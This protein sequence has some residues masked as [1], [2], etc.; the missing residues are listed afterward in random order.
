M[1]A[2]QRI[3][4][5]LWLFILIS[6]AGCLPNATVYYRPSVDVE[7][8]YEQGHCVPV[9]KYVFFNIKSKS[10]TLTVRGYGDTYT[11]KDGEL[12]S[13]GQYVISGRWEEIRYKNDDFYITGENSG[14]KIKA[15][16]IYGEVHDSYTDSSL[17][18]NSSAVFPKQEGDN[19]DIYFPMLIIDGEEI[20]L[21]VLHIKKTIWMGM[22]PF[23][24]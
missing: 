10:Q 17:V 7:S 14:E 21:P 23:N 13:S 2:M 15:V 8:T 4:L 18:F 20:E 11:G 5:T 1:P 3:K 6:L 19:F 12:V 9:D 16:R 24:C 22:S